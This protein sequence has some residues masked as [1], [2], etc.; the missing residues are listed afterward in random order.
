MNVS[1]S[2]AFSSFLLA[3]LLLSGFSVLLLVDSTFFTAAAGVFFGGGATAGAL[4]AADAHEPAFGADTAAGAEG[5]GDAASTPVAPSVLTPA[6]GPSEGKSLS[7]NV[8]G[9]AAGALDRPFLG[10]GEGDG[11]PVDEGPAAAETAFF[12]FGLGLRAGALG[13]SD[14]DGMDE[15]ASKGGDGEVNDLEISVGR[16]LQLGLHGGKA[17][18][19]HL[20]AQAR[21]VRQTASAVAL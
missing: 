8:G 21:V 11:P 2:L 9:F 13:G 1:S 3:A 15:G 7:P 4:A 10:G 6:C 20:L 12:F 16:E 17:S 18:E 5:A 14:E 19:V